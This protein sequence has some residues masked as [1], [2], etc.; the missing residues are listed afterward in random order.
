MND[1]YEETQVTYSPNGPSV[2]TLGS[3]KYVDVDINILKE[4][5][6]DSVSLENIQLNYLGYNPSDIKAADDVLNSDLVSLIYPMVKE[7]GNS[8]H[9]YHDGPNDIAIATITKATY[10]S[11]VTGSMSVIYRVAELHDFI[12]IKYCSDEI[13]VALNNQTAIRVYGDST[14]GRTGKYLIKTKFMSSVNDYSLYFGLDEEDISKFASNPYIR[15]T[16]LNV[17]NNLVSSYSLIGSYSNKYTPII[18]FNPEIDCV[19]KIKKFNIRKYLDETKNKVSISRRESWA[20]IL[21]SIEDDTLTDIAS[22]FTTED[23]LV[24]KP[25]VS[26]TGSKITVY[27]DTIAF[28]WTTAPIIS[29]EWDYST[30]GNTWTNYTGTTNRLLCDKFFVKVRIPKP[31]FELSTD[32]YSVPILKEVTIDY[33]E[34]ASIADTNG[35]FNFITDTADLSWQLP[36]GTTG[37]TSLDLA[38][39][40]TRFP[41]TFADTN[42]TS[43][44]SL[45]SST[46]SFSEAIPDGSIYLYSL[47]ANKSGGLVDGPYTFG[48]SGKDVDKT[49]ISYNR[50]DK[51]IPYT[52]SEN[53]TINGQSVVKVNDGIVLSNNG[54]YTNDTDT[55]E[56][57]NTVVNNGAYELGGI[58]TFKYFGF[59]SGIAAGTGLPNI[60]VKTALNGDFE[61]DLRLDMPN[62]SSLGFNRQSPMMLIAFVPK[63]T[64][65]SDLKAQGKFILIANDYCRIAKTGGYVS[66]GAPY[67]C[68]AIMMSDGPGIQTIINSLLSSAQPAMPPSQVGVS[69]Y[70]R[71]DIGLKITRKIS[72]GDNRILEIQGTL[73]GPSATEYSLIGNIAA[74]KDIDYELYIGTMVSGDAFYGFKPRVREIYF[75]DRKAFEI[76]SSTLNFGATLINDFRKLYLG[77]VGKLEYLKIAVCYDHQGKDF[78]SGYLD[79]ATDTLGGIPIYPLSQYITLSITGRRK[80]G[81]TG[82]IYIDSFWY[83]R[84]H[85]INSVTS[86]SVDGPGVKL[87][88][89][90][91][92]ADPLGTYGGVRIIRHDDD[93]PA[94]YD[95]TGSNVFDIPVGTI[96]FTDSTDLELGKIYY[97]TVFVKDTGTAGIAYNNYMIKVSC[98]AGITTLPDIVNTLSST[99]DGNQVSTTV[100]LNWENPVDPNLDGVIIISSS[101]GPVEDPNAPPSMY[102]AIYDLPPT[103]TTLQDSNNTPGN[104][105]YY[106]IFTYNT[107]GNFSLPLVYRVENP[108]IHRP[109]ISSLKVNDVENPLNIKYTNPVFSWVYSN[110]DDK[111]QVLYE[112]EIASDSNFNNLLWVSG[113]IQSSST[114]ATYTGQDLNVA[115]TYY[116]RVRVSDGDNYSLYVDDVM[117]FN[118]PPEILNILING[119]TESSVIPNVTPVFTWTY[120]DAEGGE[121]DSLKLR[122]GTTFGN[123]S[124]DTG[125]VKSSSHTYTYDGADLIS[126]T[127]YF[128]ELSVYDGTDWTIH[129]NHF[130]INS[131]PVVSNIKI[132]GQAIQKNA[133]ALPTFTWDYF[134]QDNTSQKTVKIEVG[135]VGQAAS[136]TF[137][138]TNYTAFSKVYDGTSLTRKG[139]YYINISVSDGFDY[140]DEVTVNFVT[141]QK[142]T[143]PIFISPTDGTSFAGNQKIS[144]VWTASLDINSD[145]VPILLE[146]TDDISASTPVWT[147]VAT[148]TDKDGYLL[149]CS[150]LPR[151]SKYGFRITGVDGETL[152]DS[153]TVDYINIGNHAPNKPNLVYPN[154]GNYFSYTM[155]I[156]WNMPEPDEID[157]DVYSF[158][159]E[160]TDRRNPNAIFTTIAVLPNTARSTNW[161]IEGISNGSEYELRIY[162]VDIYGAKS[163]VDSVPNLQIKNDPVPMNVR[164]YGGKVLISRTDGSLL[165][166]MDSQW[167]FE[168]QFDSSPDKSAFLIISK[169]ST[170]S[171]SKGTLVI[172]SSSGGYVIAK[173]G[174]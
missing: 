30:D 124:Y 154:E 147:T 63:G 135:V 84:S 9:I 170:V 60:K 35:L 54:I 73:G 32:D 159:L 145:K 155:K 67:D 133:S 100:T 53:S 34:S 24:L 132:D 68:P 98:V 110:P 76:R 37:I 22:L 113:T 17:T 72:T 19:Y 86:E 149:D 102:D 6:G 169:D 139:S 144:F 81:Y 23:V 168:E 48:V 36:L 96:T 88:W 158:V 152:S 8:I 11:T 41:M 122:I 33:M 62:L 31:V 138:P 104:T 126:G 95:E 27:L 7:D 105:V 77:L 156:I 28:D 85:K 26:S 89:E 161:D 61:V 101:T 106:T 94:T 119:K 69:L 59:I 142:P 40:N 92:A 64:A 38:R 167:S 87:D 5:L 99:I 79:Y 125:I 2:Q 127:T 12:D 111:A 173:Q 128:F 47:F 10:P 44:W 14:G 107:S 153:D 56:I 151:N 131:L 118:S 50:A 130:I 55:F 97:Y 75:Y 160:Y 78:T 46:T 1:F 150:N 65:V 16:A 164:Q 29:V 80:L 123:Y 108:I 15:H 129:E 103:T 148:V 114:S 162:A 171:T 43:A 21:A 141:N 174:D 136:W 121:Q 49:N 90:E 143:K 93:T 109:I 172:D 82:D 57:N 52:N 157:G 83:T 25:I 112:I 66:D 71:S 134:D 115:T 120:V 3:R 70:K 163:E 146:Q 117:S 58:D 13:G 4:L 165:Q 91:P 74:D 51:L 45:A 18:Y 116:W 137:N 42:V 140:S 20:N 39:A 166:S